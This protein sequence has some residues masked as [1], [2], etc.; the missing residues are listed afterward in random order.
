[1]PLGK[2]MEKAYEQA[3]KYADALPSKDFPL[4]ILISDFNRFAYY[5][6]S[7]E[8]GIE[9]E[10]HNFILAELTDYITL[11]GHLARY[12]KVEFKKLDPVNIEA[13]EKMGKLHDR[14]KIIGYAGHP[15]ELYLV[16]LLFCLFADD[17][18]IFDPPDM[19]IK[20]IIERTSVDGS[21]L[22]LHLQK[23]FEVLNKPRENRLKTLDEQLNQFPYIN[24]NLFDEPLESAGFHRPMRET[25]IECCTLD[26]SKISPAIFGAMF[27]SVMN[28]EERHD[29][30]AH[31]TSEEN[32]QKLIHPLFLDGLREEFN[33]IKKL[34][35]ALRKE[36]L[37]A[38]HNK[39]ASLK[40]L[41][42]ACG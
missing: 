16:R 14:L 32:I 34:S 2:D 8:P 33:G 37:R 3:K 17:T 26:W 4:G 18:G 21:D 36:R 9:P 19:F 41:D 12:T 30:G 13:A 5:D 31:Y 11:F 6:F 10:N 28:D 24:G 1:M 39:L 23:I 7:Y 40:F 20:Y 27:Q 29:I 25:L 35:P 38:F 15:L 22:A 42:P